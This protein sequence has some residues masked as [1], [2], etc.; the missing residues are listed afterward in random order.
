MGH[1]PDR[2]PQIDSEYPLDQARGPGPP[3]RSTGTVRR[4]PIAR[5]GSKVPNVSGAA[6]QYGQM[7]WR[8]EQAQS[9]RNRDWQALERE[10]TQIRMRRIPPRGVRRSSRV[11]CQS[12]MPPI[13]A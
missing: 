6:M 10:L 5:V 12:Q 3:A 4:V 1:E 13:G 11:P 8:A 2:R 7:G 9:V